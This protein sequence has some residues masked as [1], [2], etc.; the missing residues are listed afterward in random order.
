MFII[1]G[2]HKCSPTISPQKTWEG[3]IGGTILGVFISYSYY[4]FV[5]SQ[6]KILLV[7]LLTIFLSI[8]G[9]L[10]DLVFSKIKREN[11]L[12]DFSKLIP[13]HGGILDR[14]DSFIFIVMTYI[15]F[16]GIL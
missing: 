8:M 13:G 14:L 5:I 7:L 9:Q 2:K 3:C 15:F 10:G 6:E 16:I 11:A 1:I 12:K 4:Y